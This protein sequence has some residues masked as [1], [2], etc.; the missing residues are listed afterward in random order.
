VKTKTTVPRNRRRTGRRLL[1]AVAAVAMLATWVVAATATPAAAKPASSKPAPNGT[2]SCPLEQYYYVVQ[3][4]GQVLGQIGPTRGVTNNTPETNS[5]NEGQQVTGTITMS[6][7]TSVSWNAGVII[8]GVEL[9]L[10]INVSQSISVNQ[11][12]GVTVTVPPWSTRYVRYG[13]QR[14][15]T[16]GN[17][18]KLLSNCTDQVTWTTAFTPW[19]IGYIISTS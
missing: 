12:M 5:Y 2:T 7:Q 16:A 3:N 4:L 10:N 19:Y 6:V 9:G 14:S 13:V 1:T 18:Y 15:K 17:Y 8:T 11:H